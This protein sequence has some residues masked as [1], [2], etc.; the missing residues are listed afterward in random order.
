M[1]TRTRAPFHFDMDDMLLRGWWGEILGD[2]ELERIR[3]AAQWYVGDPS[4]PE[5]AR[6][7]VYMVWIEG[8]YLPAYDAKAAG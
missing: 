3:A 5:D 8:R 6:N 4:H 1:A 7:R 2:D